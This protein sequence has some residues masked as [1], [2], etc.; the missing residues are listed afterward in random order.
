MLNI[1][2]TGK[3]DFEYNRVKILLAGLHQLD[4]VNVAIFPIKSRKTF[5]KQRFLEL[6]AEADF[7]YIPPF[8][9]RDVSFIKKITT[10]PVV[11]DPLISK[12]LTKIDDYKQP[13][14]GP[15]KYFLDKLPFQ[16][17]D[18]LLADTEAHKNYFSNTFSIN[19]NKIFTLP[20]GIDSRLFYPVPKLQ[21]DIFKVGFYGS[22]VPLQGV[23][24]IIETANILKHQ[25]EIKFD[26]I[27][28]GYD[29]NKVNKL[30]H[31]YQLNNINM[32]G[33]LNYEALNEAINAFDLCLGIF[34]KSK[35][36]SMV[37][38]NKVYHYAALNKAII[39]RETPGIKEIFTHNKD[40]CLTSNRPEQMAE[41]IL[42]LYKSQEQRKRIGDQAGRLIHEN[43][44]AKNIGEKFIEILKI[45]SNKHKRPK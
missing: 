7:I 14:K 11:F 33:W 22:F 30:I 24:L 17:C 39:T 41:A 40:I 37:I 8:R 18:I 34:G 6:D 21:D 32:H 2:F 26:I 36:A 4:Q 1:L 27:G 3:S 9:H 20:I 45:Y 31:K 10:K 42:N 44:N 15:F 38:P 23:P 13:W 19:E 16:K 28:S 43:Y 35:K 12:Y 29:L 25:T 5:D